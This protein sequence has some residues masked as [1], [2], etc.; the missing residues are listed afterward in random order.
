[1]GNEHCSEVWLRCQQR[2]ANAKSIWQIL[3]AVGHR[4][5]LKAGCRGDENCTIGVENLLLR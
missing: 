4:L 5:W 1:M 3:A 2:R